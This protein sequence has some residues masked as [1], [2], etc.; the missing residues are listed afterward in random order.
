MGFWTRLECGWWPLVKAVAFITVATASLHAA[1]IYNF[2]G[3]ATS[4]NLAEPIVGPIGFELTVPNFINP[5]NPQIITFACSQLN[6]STNLFC[7]ENAPNTLQIS[8]QSAFS[9]FSALLGVIASNGELVFFDF[10]DGAFGIPGVYSGMGYSAGVGTLTVT[11]TPEGN[12]WALVLSGILLFGLR[13]WHQTVT[14]S[15]D[16]QRNRA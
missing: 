14:R 1:V 3:T 6:S 5:P 15:S 11:A 4:P 16:I 8:N 13:V 7:N 9:P 12:S 2:V 10:Q